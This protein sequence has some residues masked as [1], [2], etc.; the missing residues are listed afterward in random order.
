MNTVKIDGNFIMTSKKTEKTTEKKKVTLALQG[1]GAHGA[2]AWGVADKLLEDGRFDIQGVSGTSAGG[3]NAAC[4]IQGLIKGGNEA[5][6]STLKEYWRGMSE[7]SKKISPFQMTPQDKKN[8]NYNLDKNLMVKMIGMMTGH[9]SPYQTNPSNANPFGDFLK[10][11]FDFPAVRESTEKRLFLAATHVKS[12]KIKIF[13]NKDFCSDVLVASACLPQLF[14]AV[15]VDGEYY[16]D[17]G[18]IANPAINPLITECEASDVIMIQLTKT[19]C[20]ELPKTKAE[21]HERLSEITFNGCL[22]REMRA[23][24]FITQLI[25]QGI[26][27]EGALKRVNMHLI[28]NEEVFKGLNSSSAGNTDWDFLM[29]LHNEGRKTAQNWITHNYD[30]VGSKNNKM[31]EITFKDFIS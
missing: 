18:Y 30:N 24:Y 23:I 2:F 19:Y 9:L 11:F 7:L 16:W 15:Q 8:K 27:K 29:M 20:E 26:V 6:R 3:M 21:I 22:V 13:S 10:N 14:Q 4:I 25:D 12:G 1:G 5:A 17:G 28:K 31:D